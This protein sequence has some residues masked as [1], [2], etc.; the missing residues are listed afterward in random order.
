M[1]TSNE[2]SISSFRRRVCDHYRR[3]GRHQLPW[4]TLPRDSA[5]RA[6]P[7]PILVSEVMLQ[8]TQV[9]RVV[10]KYQ[11]FLAQFPTVYMLAQA[12]LG[13]VLV[14]WAGLGYNRRAKLLRQCALHLTTHCEGAF[15]T[16]EAKLR[17]LPGVGPYTAAAVAVFAHNTRTVM[18][19][20]NIRTVY[21]SHFFPDAAQVPDS[22]LLPYL[23]RTLPPRI[24]PW[25]WYAALMD[26]GA[27]LKTR[28]AA[29]AH[30]QSAHYR[31]QPAF[32]GSRRQ[33]RGLI[34][35][36]L[37]EGPTSQATLTRVCA[38]FSPEAVRAQ[39]AQLTH[40]EMVHAAGRTYRL[41]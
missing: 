25:R 27:H 30:R 31:P 29:Y 20:T 33:L 22:A 38:P 5:G 34:L 21:L 4:R 41:P 28:H 7:Y 39:L 12:P 24:D 36:R 19:E 18:I 6:D 15:P 26:Y 14:A 11:A 1:A 2:Q 40:E 10:P 9:T 17:A 13:E 16:T 37:R 23:H 35:R 32:A 3:Y 8:Q